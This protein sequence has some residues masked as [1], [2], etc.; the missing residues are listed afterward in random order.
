MGENR[1]TAK[2]GDVTIQSQIQN[3]TLG[4]IYISSNNVK[5][6]LGT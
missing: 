4:S 6:L 2:L 1:R 3:L 5:P